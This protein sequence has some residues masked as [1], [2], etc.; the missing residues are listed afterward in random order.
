MQ[1][2]YDE[3]GK[4]IDAAPYGLSQGP[5]DG[6]FTFDDDDGQI[7]EILIYSQTDSSTFNVPADHPLFRP[8]ALAIADSYVSEIEDRLN[9]VAKS[10]KK[11]KL[12]MGLASW[13]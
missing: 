5:H 1:L 9:L 2:T 13:I 4:D 12:N 7:Y 11:R 10:Q 3:I 8:M 6:K